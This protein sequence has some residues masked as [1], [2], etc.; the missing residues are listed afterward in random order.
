MCTR[1]LARKTCI[2]LYF[3]HETPLVF[4]IL[5]LFAYRAVSE[6]MR[7]R[8]DTCDHTRTPPHTNP[9][10]S[11]LRVSSGYPGIDVAS[12]ESSEDPCVASAINPWLW[13][14]IS[15]KNPCTCWRVLTVALF[16]LLALCGAND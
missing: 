3:I 5:G 10:L 7:H 14:T 16:T 2:L 12:A 13:G 4:S 8:V 6:E 15:I 11:G 1:I 9:P